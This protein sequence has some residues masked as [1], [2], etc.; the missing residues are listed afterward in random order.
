MKSLSEL[1]GD[2]DRMVVTAHRGFSGRYPEN[3]LLAFRKAIEVGADLI[4]FDLRGSV[5][6]VPVVLHDKTLDRTSDGSGSPSRYTLDELRQLNCSYW[7]GA[8]NDGQRLAAPA[9]PNVSIPTFEEV[10][11]LAK[12]RVGC[13]IQVYETDPRVLSE[14]CRLYDEY[15]LYDEGYLT[16]STYREAAL[17]RAINPRIELCVLERQQGMDVEALREQKAFGCRYVQPRRADVTAAFCQ[18]AQELGLHL[19]MFYSNTDADNRRYIGHG[20]RGILTDYPDILLRTLDD[21]G[22]RHARDGKEG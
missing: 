7:R 1:Y 2:P 3:T 6:G 18:A 20:L 13:N 17:V 9:Y 19:N 15:D 4:E 11:A 10:L 14:I 8:H 5:E 22:M 16:M 12:G 21:L